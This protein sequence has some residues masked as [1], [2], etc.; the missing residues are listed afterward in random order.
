[1][2]YGKSVIKC[3]IILTVYKRSEFIEEALNSLEKQVADK[4]LFE[5]LV[6]SN[7]E[8]K[9]SRLFNLNLRFILS[10][11]M[12][13]SSKLAVGIANATNEI[14]TFLEDDDIYCVNR[15][16]RI[17]SV[18]RNNSNLDYYH[19]KAL[20]FKTSGSL[21][22]KLEICSGKKTQLSLAMKPEDDDINEIAEYNLNKYQADYNLSSMAIKKN[23]IFDY[24]DI[25][26]VLGTRYIDTFLFSLSLYKSKSIYI[27]TSIETLIRIHPMNASQTVEVIKESNRDSMYSIDMNVLIA[28]FSKV[29]IL[30]KRFVQHFILSRGLDDLMKSSSISRHEVI[31]ALIKLLKIYGKY[32]LK[33]D[34]T[35]KS[36]LY[37]ISPNFMRKL[38]VKYHN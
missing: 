36:F 23:F 2:H 24:I 13:L 10:N 35:R 25:I 12:S 29:K 17:L 26:S 1:M 14:I 22:K 19:N 3:S 6:I 20:H 11:K 21:Q 7:I 38:I 18:F 8:L 28:A 16:E 15:I 33:S 9:F 31:S 30:E 4:D 27:D 5:V 34:V 32:F 37:I